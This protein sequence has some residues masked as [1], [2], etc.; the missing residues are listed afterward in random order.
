[1]YYLVNKNRE[2]IAKSK[3]F[4]R[5]QDMADAEF[6]CLFVVSEGDFRGLTQDPCEVLHFLNI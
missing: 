4:D 5:L 3:N 6:E 2:I 1:M